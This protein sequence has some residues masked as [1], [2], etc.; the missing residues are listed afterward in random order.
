MKI[1]AVH[2][3]KAEAYLQPF[4]AGTDGL[5]IR[6]FQA[7]ANDQEHQFWKY[8]EDY[9][10]YCIGVWDESAGVVHAAAKT[11]LGC[12]IQYREANTMEPTSLTIVEQMAKT[13]EHLNGEVPPENPESP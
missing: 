5:A 10:L 8:A 3:L 4:F 12:A 2:D 13:R 11:P 6:M 9:S 1:Y 7:A